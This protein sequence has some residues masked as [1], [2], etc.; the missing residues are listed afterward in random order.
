[1]SDDSFWLAT[2][3]HEGRFTGDADV[4]E[5]RRKMR[6]LGHE[7]SVIRDRVDSIRPELL[8]DFDKLAASQ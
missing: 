2:E 4:K 3:R 7:D 6:R 5:F 1:M 8:A